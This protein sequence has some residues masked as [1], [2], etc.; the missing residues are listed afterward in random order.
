LNIKHFELNKPS[1]LTQVVFTQQIKKELCIY[2]MSALQIDLTNVLFYKIRKEIAKNKLV[3][4]AEAASTMF[5]FNLSEFNDM[6][7][8]YGSSDYRQIV[9]QLDLLSDIKII[10]NSIGK[11]K[12]VD[13]MIITRFIQE[14]RISKHR[15]T[16]K[17]KIKLAISNTIINRFVDVKKYFSKMFLTIQFSMNSKYSKL[18]YELL[19]DY[20][21]IKVKQ[22][23]VDILQDLLNVTENTQRKWSIFQ[24]N[25]L[26]KSIKEINDKSDIIVSY[27]PIKG[28][29]EDNPRLHVTKIKFT[30]LKQADSKLKS[31]G[32]L[33]TEPELSTEE[34]IKYNRKKTI[35]L[36]RLEKSKEFQDIENE[37]AW[38]EKTINSITDSY[39]EEQNS[40]DAA[41]EFLQQIDIKNYTDKLLIKYGDLVGLK[42]YCLN[43][44]YTDTR[45][46]NNAKETED[47]LNSL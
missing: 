41:K 32:L 4:D 1:E 8:L 34:Q 17:K 21:G 15:K 12:E 3:I 27:E 36:Q 42:D 33:D 46:T 26:K 25:I 16:E 7:P 45:I 6:L 30:I 31:L 13:E 22:F 35:A 47:I 44:I 23:E 24:T 43:Y 37:S 39:L 14:I 40:I 5:E 10:I 18:L 19:K 9:E 11:N 38:I 29:T 20:E 28:R 2:K